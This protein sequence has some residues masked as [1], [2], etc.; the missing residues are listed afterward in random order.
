MKKSSFLLYN[1][2]TYFFLIKIKKLNKKRKKKK[3]KNYFKKQSSRKDLFID[4]G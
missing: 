2:K 3:T 4:L 1:Y